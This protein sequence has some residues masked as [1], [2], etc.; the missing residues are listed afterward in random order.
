VN[1]K[2]LGIKISVYLTILICLL[3]SFLIWIVTST[4]FNVGTL[5]SFIKV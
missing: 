5:Q 1:K 3:A 4:S 2:F